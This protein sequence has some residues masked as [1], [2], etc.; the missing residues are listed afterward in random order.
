M[1]CMIAVRKDWGLKNP[2]SHTVTGST[3]SVVQ[4]SSSWKTQQQSAKP[5]L[6][7]VEHSSDVTEL[8]FRC[9]AAGVVWSEMNKYQIALQLFNS[10][11]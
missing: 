3:K 7:T 9:W 2:A 11:C 5:G 1:D 4:T 6:W 8:S 10:N